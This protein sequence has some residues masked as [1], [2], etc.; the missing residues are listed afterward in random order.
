MSTA[1]EEIWRAAVAAG[2]ASQAQRRAA[3]EM[4]AQVDAEPLSP[5]CV[6]A[7]VARAVQARAA[8]DARARARSP[9]G[10]PVALMAAMTLGLLGAIGPNWLWPERSASLLTLDCGAAVIQA[11]TDPDDAA[12]YL[13]V[14]V[15][16][17]R[18]WQSL[19]VLF[20]LGQDHDPALATVAADS[21][22]RLRSA[23]RAPTGIEVAE[24]DLGA[25]CATAADVAKTQLERSLATIQIGRWAAQ[26]AHALRSAVLLGAERQDVRAVWLRQLHDALAP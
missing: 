5:Q 2:G 22:E 24:G 16:E 8:A 11:M 19:E 6:D 15:L 12:R 21:L 10:L 20:L 4:L 9:W 25:H 26:A 7:M 13:A 3:E 14:A 18:V 17:E 1:D 23:M